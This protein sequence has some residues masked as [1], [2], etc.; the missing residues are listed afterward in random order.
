MLIEV[1]IELLV[2]KI[3]SH[4]CSGQGPARLGLRKDKVK[5]NFFSTAKNENV[6]SAGLSA[7]LRTFNKFIK[8]HLTKISKE[9]QALQIHSIKKKAS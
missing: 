8:T 5:L 2:L 3:H 1:T 7:G 4:H 9:N 6:A